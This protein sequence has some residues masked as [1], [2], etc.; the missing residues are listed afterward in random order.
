MN[1]RIYLASTNLSNQTQKRHSRVGFRLA[2]PETLGALT[3]LSET[4]LDMQTLGIYACFLYCG[5][6]KSFCVHIS[7]QKYQ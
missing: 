1:I 4:D 5:I 7:S 6:P 3:L 2:E